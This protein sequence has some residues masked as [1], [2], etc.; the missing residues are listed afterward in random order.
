MKTA[1]PVLLLWICLSGQTRV[2]GAELQ[3]TPAL[4]V[5][6]SYDV[7]GAIER[8]AKAWAGTARGSGTAVKVKARR[9]RACRNAL[10]KGD[11]DLIIISDRLWT[12]GQAKP[13]W[14]IVF[15]RTRIRA[16][17]VRLGQ[18]CVAFATHR[19]SKIGRISYDQIRQ[20]LCVSK[21][22]PVSRPVSSPNSNWADQFTVYGLPARSKS[23][24]VLRQKVIWTGK[25]NAKS[26][27]QF[28]IYRKIGGLSVV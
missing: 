15:H 18:F 23:Y 6:A 1:A 17:S 12:P 3:A 2:F 4:R 16:A 20:L 22:A 28:K 26:V 9:G 10:G 24:E 11:A 7:C 21:E 5:Y 19:Q 8:I 14:D 27:D 13:K 25:N